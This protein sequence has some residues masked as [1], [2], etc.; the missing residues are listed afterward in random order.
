M[1]CY[2]GV[3]F[4]RVYLPRKSKRLAW[5][6]YMKTNS[7]YYDFTGLRYAYREIFTNWDDSARW[8]DQESFFDD[9]Y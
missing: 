5:Q 9:N 1:L 6:A 4:S 7:W 8:E 3:R 2:T